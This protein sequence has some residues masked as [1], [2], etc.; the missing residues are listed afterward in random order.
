MH[1]P[2]TGFLTRMPSS[3]P[4][5]CSRCGQ[6]VVRAGKCA[7]HYSQDDRARGTATER[8]YSSKAHQVGFRAEVLFKAF[9]RCQW[10]AGC[11]AKATIADHFPHTRRELMRIGLNPDDP[12]FGRALCKQHHDSHTASTSIARIER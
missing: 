11:D 8:G 3:P 6:P 4:R 1:A 9:H 12:Q 7:K 10:P 2:S 5:P